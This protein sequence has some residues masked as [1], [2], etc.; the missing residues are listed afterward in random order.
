MYARTGRIRDAV[1]EAQDIIKRDPNNLQARKLLGRIY[2]RSMGDGQNGAPSAEILKL[3]VEQ[4]QAIVRQEPKNIDNHLLLGHLYFLNKDL[5]KAESELKAALEIDPG[6]EEA[7]S[8][9][10]FL[11]NEQGDTK[12]AA[13]TLNAVPDSRRTSK[14]YGMLG[15]TYEQLKDYKT[16]IASYQHALMLDKDN[17]DAM[18][19]LAQN[20]ASDNQIQAAVDQYK[21]L[22]EADPQDAQASVRLSE[23]YRRTGKFDLAM[24][25]LKRA[26][27]LQQDS[28]EVTYS[29]AN[30]LEAQG[31]YEEA[32][33]ALQKLIARSTAPADR[34]NLALFLDH[35]G[36]VYRLSGKPQLAQETYRRIVD[37]GGEESARGYSGL[38]D[39]YREQK[40]WADATRTAR[41]AVKKLP[42]DKNLRMSLAQQLADEG[43]ADESISLA[44]SVAKAAPDDREAQVSLSQIYARLKRWQEAED[45]LTNLQKQVTRPEEKQYVLF[46]LGATYEREK[47]L[48]LAE[49]TFRKVLQ[50][51][52][53]SAGALNY[54]GY[55]MADHN[56]NLEES[57]G[58]IKKAV[59]LEP[60]NAAYLDSLGWA[61]FKLGNYDLA[62]QNLRRAME[63][64]PN[65]ATMH[66]HL[67]E[68]Y[69]KTGKLKMAVTHWERALAE[70]GR[71]ASADVDQED[72]GRVQKKLENTKTKL[73]QQQH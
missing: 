33:A 67:G 22:Q 14:I 5:P 70:W 44:Q 13:E 47:K 69:A 15:Y 28:L 1:L 60:E 46:V 45:V 61:Y 52:P 58:M 63:R 21:I 27:S 40:Q 12:R 71:S 10:A 31:K 39:S 57:L 34:H 7:V 18:R 30:I 32:A 68:L 8:R 56:K 6:S 26:E 24:E 42:E 25:S 48:D 55:M 62:E 16:A 9:L 11:Y 4:Y 53:G 17:M 54:L 50:Q 23:L 49:Q 64:N 36:N 66:D 65:D 19:G 51:D 37:M 59:E 3:A 2:L 29:Q 72:V 20:L 43:K 73:A 41:E 38:I 35:L